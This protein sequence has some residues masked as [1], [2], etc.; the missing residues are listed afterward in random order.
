MSS[1]TSRPTVRLPTSLNGT[2]QERARRLTLGGVRAA[3][4]W[5][6]VLL[7]LAYLPVAYLTTGSGALLALLTLHI[8]CV[9]LGH[10]HNNPE[11]A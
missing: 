6:A 3:A 4:F 8:V 11:T 2:I 10:E 7:P 9:V 5:A 1:Q